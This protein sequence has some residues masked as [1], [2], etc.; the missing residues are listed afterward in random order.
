MLFQEIIK[1]AGQSLA[2]KAAKVWQLH[3]EL[4]GA[5]ELTTITVDFKLASHWRE[6]DGL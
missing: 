5:T 4:W 3:H 1:F 6:L 2:S